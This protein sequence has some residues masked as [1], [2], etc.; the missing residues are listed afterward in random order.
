MP[1]GA[2][3]ENENI[4]KRYFKTNNN[5]K[6]LKDGMATS[7]MSIMKCP[8]SLISGMVSATTPDTMNTSTNLS[9]DGILRRFTISLDFII[10]T[11]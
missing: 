10:P 3:D 11:L 1:P 6:I 5:I 2:P 7:S 4:E 8:P 9:H